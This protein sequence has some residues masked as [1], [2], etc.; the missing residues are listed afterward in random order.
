MIKTII[1]DLGNVIVSFDH[2]KTSKRL[3]ALSE[4]ADDVI[5]A[6]AV[7]G[8]IVKHYNLG[9]LSTEEFLAAVNR[10][11]GLQIGYEDFYAAWNCT[12]LPEPLISEELIKKLAEKYK[13]LILSDTNEMHF[14]FI[15]ENYPIMN[16]FDDF[17][18][19][20]K[21]NFVKPSAEI[22]QKAVEIAGHR[23][24]ECLFI[25]D[26]AANVE[27]ARQCGIEALQFVSA[28]QLERDLRKLNLL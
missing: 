2:R 7:A 28:E 10:E 19:S 12:F 4:H 8:E 24:E 21:V 1:F 22:F 27:G 20:H 25:D 5:Y 17:V 18:V 15:R 16:Y 3:E 14:D 23:P 13:L 6:K 11:L 26:L 9:R